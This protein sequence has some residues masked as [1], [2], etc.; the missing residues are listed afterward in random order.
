MKE[1]V[2]AGIRV[3]EENSYQNR[4]GAEIKNWLNIFLLKIIFFLVQ[5]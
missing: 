1:R 2:K 4:S 5:P 3:L